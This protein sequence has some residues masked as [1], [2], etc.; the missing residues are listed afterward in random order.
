MAAAIAKGQ[1]VI[2]SPALIEECLSFVSKDR[3]IQEAEEG[4]FDDLVVAAAI[5]WQVRSRPLTRFLTTRPPGW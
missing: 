2:R 1:I 4:K 3:G 5:A